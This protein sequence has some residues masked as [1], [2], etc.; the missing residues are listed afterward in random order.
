MKPKQKCDFTALSSLPV[1]FFFQHGWPPFEVPWASFDV[2]GEVTA[3]PPGREHSEQSSGT[4]VLRVYRHTRYKIYSTQTYD[5]ATQMFPVVQI[6]TFDLP[7]PHK[8][9]KIALVHDSLSFMDSHLGDDNQPWLIVLFTRLTEG[10]LKAIS[11]HNRQSR[12]RHNMQFGLYV[13]VPTSN[14]LFQSSS[15]L[16]RTPIKSMGSGVQVLNFDQ[17]A[18]R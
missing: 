18:R 3:G 8:H 6:C 14:T 11:S 1:V 12:W 13:L 2:F 16:G 17:S 15:L 4:I 7:F 9:H 10:L 5:S